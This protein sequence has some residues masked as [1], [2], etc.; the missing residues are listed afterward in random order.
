MGTTVAIDRFRRRPRSADA[1][2]APERHPL[3]GVL[4]GST[5]RRYGLMTSHDPVRIEGVVAT[6]GDLAVADRL[7]FLAASQQRRSIVV[8]G[9]DGWYVAC[10]TDQSLDAAQ[11]AELHLDDAAPRIMS[12]VTARGITPALGPLVA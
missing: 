11:L 8:I 10:T 5:E 4:L 3:E 12:F 6:S 2:A 1:T 9:L 7:A